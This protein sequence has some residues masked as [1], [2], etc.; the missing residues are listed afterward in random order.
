V[1]S[2][3]VLSPSRLRAVGGR[4]LEYDRIPIISFSALD[5][6][7]LKSKNKLS[8]RQRNQAFA[9]AKKLWEEDRKE[10]AWEFIQRQGLFRY[11]TRASREFLAQVYFDRN[12]LKDCLRQ[13]TILVR[14]DPA[15]QTIFLHGSCLSALNR[16]KEAVHFLKPL[17]REPGPGTTQEELETYLL[18]FRSLFDLDQAKALTLLPKIEEILNQAE[19]GNNKE[20]VARTSYTLGTT[21]RHQSPERALQLLDRAETCFR[22]LGDWKQVATALN[23]KAFIYF[24]GHR[25]QEAL[26]CYRKE[27]QLCRK[28]KSWNSYGRCLHYIADLQ[29]ELLHFRRAVFLL[30]KALSLGPVQHIDPLLM[31]I[32]CEWHLGAA[33][34]TLLQFLE[35]EVHPHVHK[36]SPSP[37][38]HYYNLLSLLHWDLQNEEMARESLEIAIRLRSKKGQ[39]FL[40]ASDLTNLASMEKTRPRVRKT[41]ARALQISRKDPDYTTD[42][43][44]RWVSGKA[45]SPIPHT[46]FERKEALRIR[47]NLNWLLGPLRQRAAPQWGWEMAKALSR[48]AREGPEGILSFLQEFYGKSPIALL[49]Q[50]PGGDWKALLQYG[51]NIQE[52]LNLGPGIG[53]D[54]SIDINRTWK[55]HIRVTSKDHGLLL[56]LGSKNRYFRF[57]PKDIQK[58]Q[59]FL[60]LLQPILQGPILLSPQ[61]KRRKKK[62][63]KNPEAPNC[64]LLAG[65]SPAIRR[66][67]PLV[68]RFASSEL[69][70]T[71]KGETGTGK[72]TLSKH[73]HQLSPRGI[74]PLVLVDCASLQE[75][76]IESELLGHVRGA[77]TGAQEDRAGQFH[78]AAGGTLVLQNPMALSLRGQRLLLGAIESGSFRPL[79][80]KNILPFNARILCTT[81]QDLRKGLDQGTLLPEL[82]YR[83]S[84][85]T[86]EL[87]PLR[88]RSP[89]ILP[90]IQSMLQEERYPYFPKLPSKILQQLQREAWPGNLRELRNRIKKTL[91]LSD[92]GDWDPR[93]LLGGQNLPYETAPAEP[94]DLKKALREFERQNLLEALSQHQGHRERT[95]RA[96]GISRR[97]LQKRIRD[98]GL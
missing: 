97:W 32:E 31:L 86:L 37:N 85:V 72:K 75:G 68:E 27:A 9:Q 93:F 14:K 51:L 22:A 48:A 83:L 71:L 81:S 13:T 42:Q 91:V 70:L 49:A 58:L 46:P 88:E 66:L 55:S 24:V 56:C 90:L 1:P 78:L 89:D 87:P 34:E 17:V 2:R 54:L 84:G 52:A 40:V 94:Q 20:L 64:P 79:G 12:L 18:F 19:Q 25:L 26:A 7:H 50:L 65:T 30:S 82:Y 98:L 8:P 36:D 76:L 57:G 61:S 43:I 77:F 29:I 80:G 62:A 60:D 74:G 59:E 67:K 21:L 33:P 73:I 15:P 69:P 5:L 45:D 6:A 53:E 41:L 3:E 23:N 44:R 4:K 39:E 35:K 38:P 95:A 28:M 47:E 10:E 63:T 11:R 16:H 96:L 92:E